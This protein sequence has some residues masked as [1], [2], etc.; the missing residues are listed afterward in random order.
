MGDRVH[1]SLSAISVGLR[2]A[3]TFYVGLSDS[4]ISHPPPF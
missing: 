2:L 3:V 4:R 1:F